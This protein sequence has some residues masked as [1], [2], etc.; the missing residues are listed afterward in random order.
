MKLGTTT[1][2]E[3]STSTLPKQ[4]K[5]FEAYATPYGGST[6]LLYV[7]SQFPEASDDL[8]NDGRAKPFATLNRACIEIA[9]RSILQNRSDDTFAEQFVIMLLPG[10]NVVYNEP[11]LN[12]TNFEEENE[13]F[14]DDQVITPNALRSFN[15]ETGG[16]LLPR[17]TSITSFDMRKT[18]IRPTY[19]PKWDRETY[20][21]H[22]EKLEGRTNILKWTGGSE[23]SHVTFRDKR[24]EVSVSEIDG[25]ADTP[26]ILQSIIPHGFRTYVFEPAVVE[27]GTAV[28]NPVTLCDEVQLTYPGQVSQTYEGRAVVSEGRYLVNPIDANRFMLIDPVNNEPL[29]RR[30]LPF[31]PDPGTQPKEF[32]S[33]TY[34]NT[35]H[36]RLTAIGFATEKELSQFYSK[37][38]RAFSAITFGGRINDGN[39]AVSEIEI[40]TPLPKVPSS[41]CQRLDAHF[42]RTLPLRTTF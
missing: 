2:T 24:D 20:T 39:V 8:S 42:T 23:L 11:G 41:F 29:L 5:W 36:H 4:K 22:P 37:V 35:S 13:T 32:L 14:Q 31:A 6:T 27:N 19:Y 28:D 3:H 40:V 21:N 30:Q 38:Q 9:R 10:T 26:A 34:K 15:P 33:L 7:G 12:L 25:D 1:A 16:L 17:G 18:L